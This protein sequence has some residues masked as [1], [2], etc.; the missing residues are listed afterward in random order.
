SWPM[1]R[2]TASWK[3]WRAGASPALPESEACM[4]RRTTAAEGAT[5]SRLMRA[6]QAVLWVLERIRRLLAPL[7]RRLFGPAAVA[8]TAGFRSFEQE[9]DAVMSRGR[10]QRAQQ[11]VRAAVLVLLLLVLWA[12]F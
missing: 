3:R 4:D 10:T 11:I 12:S 7:T 5:H 9:A 6:A 1:A 8:E 2:A